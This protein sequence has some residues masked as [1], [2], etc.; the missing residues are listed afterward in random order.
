[1]VSAARVYLHHR[2]DRRR[3][4]RMNFFNFA[5]IQQPVKSFRFVVAKRLGVYQL[6]PV[7]HDLAPVLAR[8]TTRFGAV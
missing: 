6:R 3:R 8:R 5:E 7:H 1:M 4:V 2:D